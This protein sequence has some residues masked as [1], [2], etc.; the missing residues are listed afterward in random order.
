ME[1]HAL[2]QRCGL[3]YADLLADSV[4]NGTAARMNLLPATTYVDIPPL[5][6]L[7][8]YGLSWTDSRCCSW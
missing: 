8:Q 3:P 7:K 6:V 5:E 2:P 1:M 4:N